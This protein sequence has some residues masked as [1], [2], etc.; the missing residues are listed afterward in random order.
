MLGICCVLRLRRPPVNNQQMVFLAVPHEQQVLEHIAHLA[1]SFRHISFDR[2]EDTL[3]AEV[4]NVCFCHSVN[5]E[6]SERLRE[7]L[8]LRL[9][10]D[11]R[12]EAKTVLLSAKSIINFILIVV[13]CIKKKIGQQ[14]DDLNQSTVSV[15]LEQ[16]NES[17]VNEN[18]C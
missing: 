1:A 14:R 2:V 11:R 4:V 16:L 12:I 18:C 10:A 13:P 7:G 3:S 8:K 15:T 5:C 9:R 17:P 6:I